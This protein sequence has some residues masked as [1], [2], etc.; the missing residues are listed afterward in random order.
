ML[1]VH[2][3]CNEIWIQQRRG[4]RLARHQHRGHRGEVAVFLFRFYISLFGTGAMFWEEG[5]CSSA[6]CGR[7]AGAENYGQV[8]II[9]I[10]PRSDHS[11][12]MSLTNSLTHSLTTLLKT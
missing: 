8:E 7:G 11:L 6:A 3:P 2:R 10:G 1:C 12:P 5:G 9:F 4:F